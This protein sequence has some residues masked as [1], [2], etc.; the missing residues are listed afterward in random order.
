VRHKIKFITLL[1]YNLVVGEQ[2]PPAK[3]SRMIF[4][5]LKLK[6]LERVINLGL[7]LWKIAGAAIGWEG[8]Q[9]LDRRGAG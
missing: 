9:K 6:I 5:M 4:K 3:E 2:L 8:G 7:P 1:T